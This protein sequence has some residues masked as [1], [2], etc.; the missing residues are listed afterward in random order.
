[1]ADEYQRGTDEQWLEHS[2]RELSGIVKKR[3]RTIGWL[4]L[5]IV[6]LIIALGW[7]T[8][9]FTRHA[10]IQELWSLQSKQVN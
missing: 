7:V 10:P 4:R 3:D 1:M 8:F 9:K 2:N 6:L 5:C